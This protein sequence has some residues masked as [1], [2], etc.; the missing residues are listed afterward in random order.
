MIVCRAPH[1]NPIFRQMSSLILI[2]T[3]RI[4]E[5]TFTM[6]CD[7]IHKQKVSAYRN[8]LSAFG[9]I[10]QEDSI[11][12]HIVIE[13]Y[14]N[15]LCINGNKNGSTYKKKKTIVSIWCLHSRCRRRSHFT[16]IIIQKLEFERHSMHSDFFS[17]NVNRPLYSRLLWFIEGLECELW[18]SDKTS[19]HPWNSHR[20]SEWLWFN[21]SPSYC[22]RRIS[23]WNVRRDFIPKGTRTKLSIREMRPEQYARN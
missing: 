14:L 21:C 1:C 8:S 16:S 5:S 22:R 19:H 23:H 3:I 11:E 2:H 13:F 17:H 15:F 6:L 7:Q 20:T 10:H 4:S 12:S 9:C 18:F